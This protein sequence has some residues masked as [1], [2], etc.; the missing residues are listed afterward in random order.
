MIEEPGRPEQ[1]LGSAKGLPRLWRA[2]RILYRVL[3]W[4]FREEEALRLELLAILAAVPAALYLVDDA[5][6]R[7]LLIGSVAL[8][9]IVELLNTA[10]EVVVDRIG[11]EYHE[12]SGLA[13]DLGSAA[14]GVTLLLTIAIWFAI[15]I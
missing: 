7:V 4:G 1:R 2:T 3:V 14:V 9:L 13:K 11:I 15:L 8:V 6:S 10:V 5:V 12:L